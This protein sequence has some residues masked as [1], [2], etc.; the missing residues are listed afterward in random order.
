MLRL[1]FW[2]G[3]AGAL[4]ALAAWVLFLPERVAP[5]DI[6]GIEPDLARGE[7]V[8]NAAGCASCHSVQRSPPGQRL[9][10]AGGQEFKSDFGTF[11]APNISSH[12]TA[13]IGSWSRLDIVNAVRHGTSPEG[14]HYY[15]AFPYATY[16]RANLSDLVSLAAYLETLPADPTPSQPH[17]I[18]FPFNIRA[19]VGAWKF[20]YVDTDWVVEATTE[21]EERGRYLV[22]ALGH[23]AE[24]HTPRDS[25]GGLDRTRWMA[26][27]PNPSGDGRIPNITP[28]ELDWSADDIAAYLESGFTPDFDVVGGSMASV[29]ISLSNL[30]PEDHLAI[31]NYLKA[32]PAIP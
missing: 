4:I 29:V 17:D 3:S 27:A 20:L 9:V 25:L 13:G 7:Y 11:V 8:F 22:E 23:C 19:G 14:R 26:G 10:L 1:V 21:E 6:A 24:C 5:S 28:A 30:P 12:P 2:I 18:A 16:A 32:L 31:A 15:P